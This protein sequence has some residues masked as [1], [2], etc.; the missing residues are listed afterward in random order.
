M[1]RVAKSRRSGRDPSRPLAYIPGM[2]RL[3]PLLLIIA[4]VLIVWKLSA[5]SSGRSLRRQSRPLEN[6]QVEGLLRRLGAAAG[7]EGIRLRVLESPMING[8]ATPEGDIYVTRG[9]LRQLQAARISPAEF[10]SVIAHELGHLALGHTRR[11]IV[12][13]AGAQA[14]SA[15]LGG[16]LSRILPGVG[17]Y[18]ARW[19]GNLL[20]ARLSRQDEFEADAYATALMLRS[21]LGAEAQAQMLEKLPKLVPG[22]AATG[23]AWLASHPPVAERARAIRENAARWG[24]PA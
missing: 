19:L 17:W 9:L 6:D 4:G 18:I 11:R 16:V 22:M 2:L 20:V 12:D 13:V 24:A 21:D 10:A 3:L 15:I 14:I 1:A 5:W 7:V 23:P 8:L